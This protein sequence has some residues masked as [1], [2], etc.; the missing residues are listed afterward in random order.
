MAEPL[1][2]LDRARILAALPK[3][4][5]QRLI[6]IEI[7]SVLDS[8]NSYALQYKGAMPYACLAE[9]QTAGH[10]RHGRQWISPIGSGLCLSLKQRIQNKPLSGLNIA[11]AVTVVR[12][13]HLLG[14]TDV[15]IK[16]PND[17]LWQGRKL[18]GL[19][20]ESGKNSEI[21]FGI[22]INVKMVECN[23]K[24]INQP[25]VDLYS[26]LGQTS[27]S[28]NILAA[29]IIEHCLQTLTN[30]PQLGLNAFQQDW[31][32][33]DLSYGQLVTLETPQSE[34][35]T[36]STG[37]ACGIDEEGALLLQIGNQ[38]QRYVDGEVSLRL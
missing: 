22:G 23:S 7:H 15:G 31:H 29:K 14:A 8:T 24:A 11:L 27:P 34:N 37:I 9:Y 1:E 36:Y 33:F 32:R 12:V 18:A 21:V 16:W 4:T 28:R 2:L 35:K 19:L 26:I 38:K 25:Y 30:Y 3:E 5:R 6:H 20:L 13:L 10:G 17:I